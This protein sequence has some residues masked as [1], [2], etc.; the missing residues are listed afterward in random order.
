MT[1][2]TYNDQLILRIERLLPGLEV[3]EFEAMFMGQG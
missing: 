1:V 3:E 2:N